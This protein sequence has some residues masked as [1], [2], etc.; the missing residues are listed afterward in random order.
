MVGWNLGVA[1]GRVPVM[2]ISQLGRITG[3]LGLAHSPRGLEGP[4]P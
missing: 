4:D 3:L 1:L 2:G